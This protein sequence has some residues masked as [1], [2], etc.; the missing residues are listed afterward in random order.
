MINKN[1]IIMGMPGA[2]KGTVAG[3]LKQNGTLTHLST[4]EIF[5]S[6]IK[7]KTEL[8]LKVQEYVTSGGYVPDEITNQIVKNAI[9]KFIEKGERFILDGYPRTLAQAEFL[10]DTFGDNFIVIELK[11]SKEVVLERLGGR[12]TCP[13]CQTGYHVLFKKPQV[14]NKCDLDSSELFIREDDKA[15]KITNRL[16]IYEEQTK[17]LLDFYKS[18]NALVTVEALEAPN[19]VAE[20]VLE[21]IQKN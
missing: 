7:N 13:T 1:V 14:E 5:R 15:E 11:V 12:R 9:T 10:R 18:Q 6:E 8:G 19:K 4:G 2:G 17:P 20:K 3:I 21:I 16:E